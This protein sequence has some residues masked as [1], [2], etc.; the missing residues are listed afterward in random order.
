L[1]EIM[2][3]DQT[4]TLPATHEL[5]TADGRVL[6]YCFYGPRDGV[7]VIRHLGSPGTRWL[8]PEVVAGTDRSGLRHLAY[9]RPGY[10]GSTRRP[11]RTVADAVA[12]V[13]ALADAQGWERFAILGGSGGGPHALACAALL[14]DRVTRCAVVSGI[15]PP[16]LSDLDRP[17]LR[18]DTRRAALGEHVLRPHIE[19]VS[20]GI[21][22]TF[23][24]GGP[25]ILPDPGAPEP[26]PAAPRPAPAIDD[27][28]AMARLRATFETGIDGWVDDNLAFVQPWGFA[29]RDITVPVGI[30]YGRTDTNIPNE[31]SAWLLS[32]IATAQEHG[33]DG[34]HLPDAAT[35]DAIHTWLLG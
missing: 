23:H 12:D 35:Y 2:T 14:P 11:G 21:M 16:D 28:A 5:A 20:R 24:A 15:M 17:G 27:P 7:P 3:V 29:M 26:D 33:Y 25:E 9:D 22:A 30:W 8:R 13:V 19:D 1:D 18:E 6:R 10:G 32:H 4:F 31:Q 34:G